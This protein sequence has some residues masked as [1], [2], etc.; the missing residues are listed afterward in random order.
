MILNKNVKQDR[1]YDIKKI[2]S[3]MKEE[4]S[5]TKQKFKEFAAQLNVFYSELSDSI[6]TRNN[7]YNKFVKEL[8]QIGSKLKYFQIIQV[9]VQL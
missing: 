2:L 7:D 5:I 4:S 3:V 9:F 8:D 6:V 1:D